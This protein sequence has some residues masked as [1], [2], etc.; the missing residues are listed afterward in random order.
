VGLHFKHVVTS[1][2]PEAG[3]GLIFCA[4]EARQ[5]RVI[6]LII[7]IGL[8]GHIVETEID[9]QGGMKMSFRKPFHGP[10]QIALLLEAIFTLNGLEGQCGSRDMRVDHPKEGLPYTI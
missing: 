2:L 6:R 4:S 8:G 5:L 9:L 10:Q 1:K 3:I 7:D